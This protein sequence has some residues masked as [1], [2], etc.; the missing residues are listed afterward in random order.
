MG[1][2]TEAPIILGLM[3]QT[4]RS[5]ASTRNRFSANALVNVYVLGRPSN[6]DGASNCNCSSV[7]QLEY[8]TQN[9]TRFLY[10]SIDSDCT[11]WSDC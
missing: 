6:N 1:S 9:N 5:L 10:S 7:I 2:L 8:N 11:A 4:G 3:M